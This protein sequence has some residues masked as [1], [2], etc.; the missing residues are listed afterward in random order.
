[1]YT[2]AKT[3]GF[4]LETPWEKLTERARNAILFEP[5]GAEKLALAVPPDTKIKRE[6]WQGKEVRFGG[7]AHRIERHYRRYRQRGEAS[8][9]MEEW[10][11]KVMVER[12]CPRLQQVSCLSARH[13]TSLHHR[14][15]DDFRRRQSPFR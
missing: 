9:G 15:Q 11:E 1:M 4:S 12:T 7:I 3:I 10:L 14:G 8:A 2:L 13:A 6:D 5:A